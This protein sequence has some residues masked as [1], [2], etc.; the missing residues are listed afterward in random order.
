MSVSRATAWQMHISRPQ[1]VTVFAADA[2]NWKRYRYDVDG[3]T[4]EFPAEPY[5]KPNN[6]RTGTRYVVSLDNNKIA[7]MV[8]ASALP[9]DLNKN[10]QQVLEDYLHGTVKGSKGQVKDSHPITLHG[11]PGRE[12]ILENETMIFRGRVYVVRKTLYQVLIASTRELAGG[13]EAERFQNS[14][15][16]LK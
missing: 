13:T 16:L 4:V 6:R 11:N 7:Y 14:F 1:A 15:D 2:H 10:S 5:T 12:F 3:F 8:E 9:A